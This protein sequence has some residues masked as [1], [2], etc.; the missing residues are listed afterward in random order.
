MDEL[1]PDRRYQIKAET[2]NN[3]VFFSLLI[4][5]N[6]FVPPENQKHRMKDHRFFFLKHFPEDH[7]RAFR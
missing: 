5:N 4:I 6:I 2:L 3:N 1:T 7:F